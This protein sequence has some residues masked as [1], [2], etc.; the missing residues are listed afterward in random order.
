[1]TMVQNVQSASDEQGG[2]TND[3]ERAFRAIFG[4]HWG[5]AAEVWYLLDDHYPDIHRRPKHLFW[6]LIFL[7]QYG[8]EQSHCMMIGGG[9]S[10][11][12]F[13]KWVWKV[14]EGMADLSAVV[15]SK[16]ICFNYIILYY[17]SYN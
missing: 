4:V 15:V 12:T 16:M 5:V 11:K 6:A 14:L 7:K 8:N 2:Y 9:A 3:D 17:I 10:L 1:M 13:R